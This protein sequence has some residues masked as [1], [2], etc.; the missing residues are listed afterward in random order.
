MTSIWRFRAP[1]SRRNHRGKTLARFVRRMSAPVSRLA[2]RPRSNIPPGRQD[3]RQTRIGAGDW[4]SARRH[5]PLQFASA[6]RN[7]AWSP[8]ARRLAVGTSSGQVYAMSGSY[9]IATEGQKSLPSGRASSVT[10]IFSEPAAS[11]GLEQCGLCISVCPA[12][13]AAHEIILRNSRFG[14]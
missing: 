14:L 5:R 1:E 7:I 4:K 13:E 10:R 2:F 8:H 9:T 12:F 6:I 11:R 3:R